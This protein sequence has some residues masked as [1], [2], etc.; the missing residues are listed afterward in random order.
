MSYVS[1]DHL[2]DMLGL[3]AHDVFRSFGV[4]KQAEY[5]NF[6]ILYLGKCA[7]ARTDAPYIIHVRP[8]TYILKALK[9]KPYFPRLHCRGRD[10]EWIALPGGSLLELGI[11][12]HDPLMVRIDYDRFDPGEE[13]ALAEVIDVIMG[14]LGTDEYHGILQQRMGGGDH[15]SAGVDAPRFAVEY[16]SPR[17]EYRFIK[18][19][20]ENLI[21]ANVLH[22]ERQI[23]SRSTARNQ[24]EWDTINRVFRELFQKKNLGN[25]SL[26]AAYDNLLQIREMCRVR[27]PG[28]A[29]SSRQEHELEWGPQHAQEWRTRHDARVVYFYDQESVYY[30][31]LF[32]TILIREPERL[33]RFLYTWGSRLDF[34][35]KL[36]GEIDTELVK[37]KNELDCFSGTVSDRGAFLENITVNLQG[38]KDAVAEYNDYLLMLRDKQLFLAEVGSKNAP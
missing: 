29:A 13:A 5:K 28:A 3:T 38:I 33:E 25:F 4:I 36:R 19:L 23:K 37:F 35:L 14:Y 17:Q 2:V 7:I 8:S 24:I 1:I 31:D 26:C 27:Q 11:N 20:L 9:E 30:R 10:P 21:F 12:I 34:S 18:P 22:I 16:H 6:N 32:L 15:L